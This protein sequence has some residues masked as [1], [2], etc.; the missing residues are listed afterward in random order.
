MA[1]ENRRYIII[2][3]SEI[4]NINFTEVLETSPETCRF[5]VDGS[6]TFVKYEGT[7]PSS[8][9]AITSKSQEYTHSE[10]LDI[11][12]TEEWTSNEEML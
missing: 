5:S 7:Q 9:T 2:P 3:V 4:N 6:K 12:S 11:L 1:F 8:V 10:I